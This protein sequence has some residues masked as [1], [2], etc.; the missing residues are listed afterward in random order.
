MAVPMQ[1]SAAV[2]AETVGRNKMKAVKNL[3]EGYKEIFTVNLQ[4]DKKTAVLVNVLATVIAI[5]LCVP[6]HFYISFFTLFDMEQGLGAYTLRFIVLLVLLVV[7]MVLHE[8]VHGI[9]MKLFGTKKIKYGFTGLYAFAGSDDYYPKLPYI[10]IALAPVAVLGVV[11]AVINCFVPREWFWVVYF[12]QLMN[13]S[14]AAGDMYVTAKFSRMPKDILV[15]DSGI[16]MTV[17]S[18]QAANE[19]HN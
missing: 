15:Q 16:C 17:Y 4:K 13:I 6:M 9:T 12:I 18:A 19:D 11:I 3:P 7:Y 10:I 5:A 8:L 1:S 14:G 2:N